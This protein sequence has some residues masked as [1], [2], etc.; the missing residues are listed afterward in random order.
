[1]AREGGIDVFQELLR[2]GTDDAKAAAACI[3]RLLGH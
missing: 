2:T 1:M 3:L